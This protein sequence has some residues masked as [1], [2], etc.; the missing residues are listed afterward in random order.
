MPRPLE[1]YSSQVLAAFIRARQISYFPE[2]LDVLEQKLESSMESVA[3]ITRRIQRQTART[4]AERILGD[5]L[6]RAGQRLPEE[7]L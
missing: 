2:E 6:R 3:S 1:S 4:T 7:E 5:N